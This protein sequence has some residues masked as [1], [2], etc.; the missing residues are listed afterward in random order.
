MIFQVRARDG[1]VLDEFDASE[2][3]SYNPSAADPACGGKVWH[4]AACW[5]YVAVKHDRERRPEAYA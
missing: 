4:E 1:L 3:V 2:L 5:A